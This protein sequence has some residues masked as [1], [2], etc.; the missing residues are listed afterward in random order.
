MSFRARSFTEVN[1]PRE[2]TSR[3]MRANQSYPIPSRNRDRR[4]LFFAL[5]E[6][7]RLGDRHY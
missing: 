7:C 1:T 6:G 3:S 4:T 5:A 2:I